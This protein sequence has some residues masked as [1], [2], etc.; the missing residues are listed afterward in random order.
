[1][2]T[3]TSNKIHGFQICTDWLDLAYRKAVNYTCQECGKHEDQI[4]KLTPHRLKRGNMGGLYTLWPVNKKG[5]NV[6]LVCVECHKKYHANEM[7]VR[8]YKHL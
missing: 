4:G 2:S 7:G 6:K 8:I 5:S 3:S 1:M